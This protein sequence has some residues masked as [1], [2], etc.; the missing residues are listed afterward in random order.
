MA[1]APL[2]TNSTRHCTLDRELPRKYSC[3]APLTFLKP[4]LAPLRPPLTFLHPPLAS[5]HVSNASQLCTC[6]TISTHE[7]RP[8][9]SHHDHTQNCY[10]PT[11]E[12]MHHTPHAAG[13]QQQ[14]APTRGLAATRCVHIRQATGFSHPSVLAL[15]TAS[16]LDAN[17]CC[18]F[19][20]HKH[21]LLRVL[22]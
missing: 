8:N 12:R 14:A 6:V 9:P 21:V 1:A 19:P 2:C 10:H 22:C 4:R 13:S 7:S 11:D 5:L 18:D 3:S 15:S 16:V 17:T 20:I